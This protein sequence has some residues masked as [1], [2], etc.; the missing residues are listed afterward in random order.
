[1]LGV[2]LIGSSTDTWRLDVAR[3]ATRLVA[4]GSDRGASIL[5]TQLRA[6]GFGRASITWASDPT[7]QSWD[8]ELQSAVAAT[9]A[10]SRRS[11]DR[12]L[13]GASAR[14]FTPR[15]RQSALASLPLLEHLRIANRVALAA[16]RSGHAAARTTA[17]S[18]AVRA[19]AR[20]RGAR[21]AGW[22]KVD[23]AWS[24][25]ATHRALVVQAGALLGRVPHAATRRAHDALRAALTT[26]PGVDFGTLPV[27]A[28]YPWP[29]DSAFDSQAVVVSLD[30]PGT[31]T[32][33]VYGP[34]GAVVKSSSSSVLPG[35]ATLTWDGT[36]VDGATLGPG[37]YRYN[38]DATDLAGNAVRVPGLDDFEIARDTTPP[39]VR[40]ATV[41]HLVASGTHRLVAS[42]DVEEVHSPN[43]H[44]WLLLQSGSQRQ[45]FDL[46]A[47][48]QKATVRRIVTL[49]RGTW[50]ASF[51]F[52][53][54]S[55]NR[56]SQAAGTIVVA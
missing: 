13:A 31:L 17:R 10:R 42:W 40:T 30:K 41:R 47:T 5:R 33:T 49:P 24:S 11:A 35:T 12:T 46:H 34:D 54:G 21:Q 27:A 55:G 22:S 6:A 26:P 8:A 16:E 23:G 53:D 9:L 45:S 1:V 25:L 43:V 4:A 39:T 7:Q 15:G 44:T 56:A 20:V 29:R 51:T 48:L 36:G 52:V 50:R 37:E 14:A 28:F 32:L 38:L 2:D 3:L 18:V 19:F